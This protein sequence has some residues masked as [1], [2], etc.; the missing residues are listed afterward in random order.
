MVPIANIQRIALLCLL[1]LAACGPSGPR[2][3]SLGAG[4]VVAG[5]VPLTAEHTMSAGDQFEI[6]FPF[7]PEENDRL[8]VGMDGTVAPK[9]IGTVTVGGLTVAETTARLKQRYA[10]KLKSPELSV[11]MRRYAPEMVYVDGWV[12]RPGL[13]RSDIPLTLSRALAQAGGVKT[14]AK[15]GDILIMRQGAAGG[16]Q[17]HSAATPVGG[18]SWGGGHGAG[19]TEDPLLKSF[20]VVYVPQTAI[21]AISEFAKQ[22]YTNLPFSA[23]FQINP[24][25]ATSVVTPVQA[26]APQQPPPVVSPR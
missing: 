15:T 1:L 24:T 14:G 21:T 19:G 23:S 10:G 26:L 6:R 2:L 3:T 22:Y 16:V 18:Y 9:L 7:A 12:G 17:T 5:G 4:E 25:A 8:T 11:V 13:I 20:D